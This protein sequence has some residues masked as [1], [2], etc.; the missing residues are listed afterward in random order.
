MYAIIA[1]MG[2]REDLLAGAKRCLYE[3]GYAHT[4]ARDIVAA[5][6]ANLASI[7]Y[8]FGSMEAL[9]NAAM[10]QAIQEWGAE[11]ERALSGDIDPAAAPLERFAAIWTRVIESFTTHRQLWV[12]TFEALAQAQRSPEV[13]A[14]LGDA[15]QQ[16]REGLVALFQNPDAATDEKLAGTVGS[17]YQALLTGVWV[18]WLIDPERAPSGPDLA[19]ALR[20]ILGS[21]QAA[22]MPGANAPE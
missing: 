10:I 20:L 17:L 12:A 11:L 21:V 1:H 5:S 3:R 7:G 6:G 13:R 22:E 14:F 8:H 19:E 2:H 18:Q 4:T 16:G 9:L 15:L